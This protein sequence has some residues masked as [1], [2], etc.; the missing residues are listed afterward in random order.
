MRPAKE[1]R[2]EEGRIF[3]LYKSLYGSSVKLPSVFSLSASSL[4]LQ[5]AAAPLGIRT[6]K[7]KKEE[8]GA[9]GHRGTVGSS[10]PKDAA[11]FHWSELS[12]VASCQLQGRWEVSFQ[13]LFIFHG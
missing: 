7:E 13:F 2:R 11:Y 12:H 6:T 5:D 3:C 9:K 4:E 8:V 1:P 10:L